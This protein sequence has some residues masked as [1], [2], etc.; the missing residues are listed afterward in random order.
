MVTKKQPTR[1]QLIAR[2]K[3]VRMVR[4]RAKAL[5]AAKRAAGIKTT[6]RPATKRRATAKHTVRRNIRT[7]PRAKAGVSVRKNGR[8]LYGAAAAAVL[9]S[10]KKRVA[11]KKR[12]TLL[13]NGR[14]HNGIFRS[15]ARAAISKRL[16][17][18]IRFGRRRNSSTPSNIQD[19]HKMFLGRESTKT[20]N[21]TAPSNTPK[22]VAVLGPL[23][24]L[25]TR[26]EE[27]IFA[28]GEA[29]VA[30]DGQAKK[31]YI[32]GDKYAHGLEPNANYGHI[33]EIRYEARKDHINPFKW[34]KRRR[35]ANVTEY[36][37]FFGEENGRRPR[38]QSDRDR[39]LH[40]SGGDYKIK[41]EGIIN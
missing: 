29:W 25:K 17:A 7:V 11:P 3:F 14:K 37:H 41:A 2:A 23:V 9:A 28:K 4:A 24:C 40:V 10:R 15:A 33:T 39:L 1:K 12:G 16:S 34:R 38:L 6:R 22:D 8:K 19:V 36:F 13:A 26:D 21:I 20:F 35:N 5:K 32:L 27:F 18:P 31:L 30:T